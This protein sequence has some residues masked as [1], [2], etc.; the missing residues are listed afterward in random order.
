[1]TAESN[2]AE[3]NRIVDEA[4]VWHLRRDEMNEADWH[5]FII[6][7][8]ASP[9]HASAYDRIALQDRLPVQVEA[10]VAVNDNSRKRGWWGIGIGAATAAAAALGFVLLPLSDPYSVVTQAGERRV[11]A[12]ADGTRIELNGATRLNLDHHDLRIATLD[13]GEAMFSVRHD[14]GKPFVLQAGARKIEDLGTVFNV[15][16]AGHHINVQVAE[17]AVM[18]QPG[19]EAIMLRPGT[20]LS[21]D[22]KEQSV[23]VSQVPVEGIGGWRRGILSYANVPL[24]VVRDAVERRYRVDLTLAGGLSERPFT[25]MVRLTG[26]AKRDVPHLAALIGADW[27]NDG[28]RWTLSPKDDASAR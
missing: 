6:W 7:L 18:F 24:S 16:K 10:L 4:I 8:E 3:R 23:T 28:T 17:G 15:S 13:H 21:V 5:A 25:G 27:R 19:K 9:L 26:E 2:G 1:M 20:A 12:L 14:P 11:V 22:E